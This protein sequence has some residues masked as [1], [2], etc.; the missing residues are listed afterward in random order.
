MEVLILTAVQHIEDGIGLAAFRIAGRQP[1]VDLARLAHDG[2]GQ[3]VGLADDDGRLDRHGDGGLSEGR[4]AARHRQAEAQDE[5]FDKEGA[6]HEA[7]SRALAASTTA[8]AVMP[9]SR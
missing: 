3:G 8:S 4:G 7:Y 9:N 5:G 1:D 2:G 6:A